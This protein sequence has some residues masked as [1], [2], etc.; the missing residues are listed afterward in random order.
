MKSSLTSPPKG[1]V[2]E[3]SSI[4]TP[5]LKSGITAVSI[6]TGLLAIWSLVA[7]IPIIVN[8]NGVLIPSRGLS[9][10]TA[11]SEGVVVYP[12]EERNGKPVFVPPEWSEKAYDYQWGI[13]SDDSSSNNGKIN[14][15]DLARIITADIAADEWVRFS[16]KDINNALVKPLIP[17]KSVVAIVDNS[18]ARSSLLLSLAEFDSKSQ[19]NIASLEKIEIDMKTAKV[20]SDKNYQIYEQSRPLVPT[21]M[22]SVQLLELE[23]KWLQDLGK[24]REL[25]LKQIETKEANDQALENLNQSLQVYLNKAL[26]YAW[27][28]A[29]LSQVTEEQWANVTPGSTLI[30]LSWKDEIAPN[31]IPIFLDAST[32]AQTSKGMEVIITPDGFSP[33]EIGGIKGE[34]INISPLP[35]D[36]STLANMLGISAASDASFSAVQGAVYLAEVKMHTKSIHSDKNYTLFHNKGKANTDNSGGYQWNNKSNPPLPPR[37]GQKVGVQITTRYQTPASMVLSFLKETV[38]VEV[39]EKFRNAN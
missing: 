11:P 1:F 4:L 32:Y 31:V 7:K 28:D 22:S 12:F 36:R 27:E 25:E 39:P 21:A 23:Q 14:T 18:S 16:S 8:A 15:V 9:N 17:F 38:G 3:E 2:K 20:L 6:L 34:I 26:V 5:K 33:A 19:Q 24:S 10:S 35:K 29:Y 37:T 13:S 30:T